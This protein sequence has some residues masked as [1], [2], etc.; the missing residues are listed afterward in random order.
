MSEKEIIIFVSVVVATISVS[1][2]YYLGWRNGGKFKKGDK[3]GF[4]FPRYSKYEK[5]EKA[6]ELKDKGILTEKEFQQEKKR[7]LKHKK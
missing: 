3:S 2:G 7:L 6:K 1:V 4:K 5:L